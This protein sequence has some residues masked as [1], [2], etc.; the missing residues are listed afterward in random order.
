MWGGSELCMTVLFCY[1]LCFS[2]DRLLPP[3]LSSQPMD[4]KY[5]LDIQQHLTNATDVLIKVLLPNKAFIES[6]TGS[7][8]GLSHVHFLLQLILPTTCKV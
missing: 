3:S 8:R 4:Q 1:T 5:V 7:N 2:S 6:V